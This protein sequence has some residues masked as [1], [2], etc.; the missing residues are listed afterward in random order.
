MKS[1]IVLSLILIALC[2]ADDVPSLLSDSVLHLVIPKGKDHVTYHWTQNVAAHVYGEG[3][4]GDVKVYRKYS[5]DINP[6]TDEY[7]IFDDE[8]PMNKFT[9][10]AGFYVAFYVDK[11]NN[12]GPDGINGAV[13]FV[14]STSDAGVSALIPNTFDEDVSIAMAARTASATLTWETEKDSKTTIYRKDYRLKEFNEGNDF[15]PAKY[16]NTGC[17]AKLWMDKDKDATK[18]VVIQHPNDHTY[19]GVVK[20]EQVDDDKVVIV[21]VT[22]KQK[23]VDDAFIASYKFVRLNSSSTTALSTMALLILILSFLLI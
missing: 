23:E 1:I 14:I 5:N 6:V 10:S 18:N 11:I 16:Y 20:V 17:S 19:N 9:I 15:P 12:D 7:F 8:H 2:Y 22:V 13:D 3:C 4:F 21:A